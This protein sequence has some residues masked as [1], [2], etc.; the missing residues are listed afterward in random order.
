M[1]RQPS[2]SPVEQASVKAPLR[3][4]G[5]KV[6]LNATLVNSLPSR[7]AAQDS[8]CKEIGCRFAL[9]GDLPAGTW[10]RPCSAEAVR[11]VRS[12]GL[13]RGFDIL[14][15]IAA[16]VLL[17]P[18]F[19]L[20]G[21]M[22]MWSG[23]GPIFYSQWRYGLDR[24]LFKIYKFRTMSWE[25]SCGSSVTRQ[26]SRQDSRITTIGAFLRRTSL[27]ELPQFLNVLKGDMS[28]VG[29]RPHAPRTLIDGQFIE[30]IVAD[31]DERHRVRPGMTG[32][33]QISGC[34]GPV[35]TLAAAIRR[36]E[37]DMIYV[38][39][40][41]FWLDLKIIALTATREF[42]TGSGY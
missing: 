22:V 34:R 37:F 1:G 6:E 28:V 13:K 4:G 11:S 38:R 12:P 21:A 41:D 40:W 35:P 14:F 19:V 30:A 9:D 31:Y 36:F 15:S 10:Q 17:S 20:I 29:P 23:P 39:R 26:A 25:K 33:A 32:L 16:L 7:S 27:D 3:G 2:C 8:K 5:S 24:Q 18:A 42:I